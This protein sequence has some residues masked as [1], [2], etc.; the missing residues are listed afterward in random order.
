MED[1][2]WTT[3]CSSPGT[4]ALNRLSGWERCRGGARTGS[5]PITPASSFR[6]KFSISGPFRY[7]KQHL[8]F[9]NTAPIPPRTSEN[10]INIHLCWNRAMQAFLCRVRHSSSTALTDTLWMDHIRKPTTHHPWWSIQEVSD[11]PCNHSKTFLQRRLALSSIPASRL[12]KP[13][14]NTPSSSPNSTAEFY[15]RSCAKYR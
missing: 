4:F 11:P 5:P 8:H 13:A 9:S 2:A 1:E 12:S 3:Y 7:R 14:S 6:Y 15:A 10:K